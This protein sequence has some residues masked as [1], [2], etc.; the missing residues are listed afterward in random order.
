MFNAIFNL[1]VLLNLRNELYFE[2][3]QINRVILKFIISNSHILASKV[4]PKTVA[5]YK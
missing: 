2:T 1:T 3:N 4:H 5:I